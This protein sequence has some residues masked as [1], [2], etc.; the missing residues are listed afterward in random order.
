VAKRLG[1]EIKDR[2]TALGDSLITAQVFIKFLYLLRT[3]GITTLGSALEVS[4]Q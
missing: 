2:H 1:V 3:Q 4:Q